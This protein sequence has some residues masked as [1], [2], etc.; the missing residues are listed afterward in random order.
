[1][2]SLIYGVDD[3]ETCTRFWNDFGLTPITHSAR[4]SVFEGATGSR[5]VVRARAACGVADWFDGNVVTLVVW[6]GETRE[7][8]ERLA[9]KAKWD[10]GVPRDPVD[11]PYPLANDR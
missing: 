11:T 1:M 10:R 4:E 6:G 8:L 2:E 5:L 9:A 3:M 7:S